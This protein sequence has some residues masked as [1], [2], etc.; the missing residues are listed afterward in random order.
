MWMCVLAFACL[1]FCGR[2]HKA[3]FSSI[4]ARYFSTNYIS[5]HSE[6]VFNVTALCSNIVTINSVKEVLSLHC[7]LR[8]KKNKSIHNC[9]F[10]FADM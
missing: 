8:L 5:Q 7:K 4:F 9:L 2:F 3:S 1:S 10:S 6:V